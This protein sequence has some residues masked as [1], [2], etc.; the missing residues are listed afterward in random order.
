M[1]QD[2]FEVKASFSDG[3]IH[4]YSEKKKKAAICVKAIIGRKQDNRV[5]GEDEI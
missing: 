4:E 2:H 3:I 5:L 1:M